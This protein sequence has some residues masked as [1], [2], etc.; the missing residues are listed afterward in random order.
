MHSSLTSSFTKASGSSLTDSTVVTT[1]CKFSNS[2]CLRIDGNEGFS[3]FGPGSGVFVSFPPLTPTRISFQARQNDLVVGLQVA[4]TSE[5]NLPQGQLFIDTN[6]GITVFIA[7]TFDFVVGCTARLEK[8]Q[9][10]KLGQ[11]RL[12]LW[13]IL[14]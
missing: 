6:I 2:K 1:G 12:N 5:T 4:W 10:W 8:L 7:S 13:W 9:H 11:S 14:S 3:T